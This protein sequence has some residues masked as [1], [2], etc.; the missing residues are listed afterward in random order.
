MNMV[1]MTTLRMM[2]EKENFS[3]PHH[4]WKKDIPLLYAEKVSNSLVKKN[5]VS[6]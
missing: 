1:G 4:T 6:V 3:I 5:P 2:D